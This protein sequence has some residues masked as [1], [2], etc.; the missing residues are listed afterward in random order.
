VVRRQPYFEAS[1]TG[2]H[3]QAPYY[4][5]GN[6]LTMIGTRQIFGADGTA[7]AILAG[8]YSLDTLGNIMLERSG[9]GDTG[10]TYLVSRESN[11]F[12]TPSRF[13]GF[14]ALRAYHSTGI[15]N[16]L[17]GQASSGVYPDYRGVPVIGVYQ[18]VPELDAAFL[19]EIDEQEAL[20]D[21]QNLANIGAA[22]TIAAA[23]V[24]VVVALY[25]S[26][27]V[28]RPISQLTQSAS[29]FAAGNLKARAVVTDRNEIGLAPVPVTSPPRWK[30]VVWRP[31]S[32]AA[33]N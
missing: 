7:V 26:N 27:R 3:L 23:G 22:I 9:L 10:E 6:E 17:T 14:D 11:Y 2:N 33:K 21:Y 32:P 15:D 5:I 24:A 13:E 25:N 20:A 18:F 30:S 12:L 31:A 16:A 1:L 19:A 28:S 29:E 8:T 4:Q